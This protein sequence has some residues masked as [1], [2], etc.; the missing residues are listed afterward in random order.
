V[1]GVYAP[2]VNEIRGSVLTIYFRI[3]S[4]DYT[5]DGSCFYV[6]F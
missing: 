6:L 4:G 3:A 1:V 5:F 2:P